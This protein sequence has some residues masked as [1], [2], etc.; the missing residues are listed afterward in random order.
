MI[1][2]APARPADLGEIE[3]L[4]TANGLPTEGLADHLG[5]AFV[6]RDAG[7]IVGAAG[8]ETYPDGGLL[9]SVVV[10]SALRGSGLGRQ[11][12]EAVI[13]RARTEGLPALYLLTTTASAYF[14]RLGFAAISR[15]L[16][17]SGVQRSVEFTSACPASASAMVKRL[18]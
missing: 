4:L 13:A 3:A 15:D 18:A 1:A 9:R 11:L 7:R 6:A 5:H 2:I 8:L 17:P 12:V 14:P 16:V 10:D